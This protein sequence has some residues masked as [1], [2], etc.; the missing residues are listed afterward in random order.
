MEVS[1]IM[2]KPVY[3]VNYG[4]RISEAQAAMEKSHYKSVMVRPMRRGEKWRIFTTTDENRVLSRGVSTSESV[5]GYANVV[6]HWV[7]PE[8]TVRDCSDRMSAFGIDHLPVFE[9]DQTGEPM[10]M[11]SISDVLK[12]LRK[13]GNNS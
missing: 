6:E 13:S 3:A 7:T 5:G 1:V 2:T 12:F 4:D 11:V 8:T 10:G 9:E